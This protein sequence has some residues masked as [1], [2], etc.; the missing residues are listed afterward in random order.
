MSDPK[1]SGSCKMSEFKRADAQNQFHT[2]ENVKKMAEG[3]PLADADR[4]DWLIVLREQAL[5]SL[6]TATNV[7]VTCSALKRKYRDVIRIA[8]YHR[9][10]VKVHFVFL[11]VT[12]AVLMDR[13]RARRNHYMKDHMVQSQLES[14]EA[15]QDDEFDVLSIDADGPPE[16]V[17]QL[18]LKVVD[19][20]MK[21]G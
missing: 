4:W 15:P 17:Q 18:V 20:R 13:V 11:S 8:S 3:H 6:T 5:A 14:L 1:R 9:A 21:E 12:D 19:R 10:D 7:V 2:P 16:E